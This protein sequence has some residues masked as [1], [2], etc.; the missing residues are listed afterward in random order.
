MFHYRKCGEKALTAVYKKD[1]SVLYQCDTCLEA[2]GKV[3]VVRE[4][5]SVTYRM[6][7]HRPNAA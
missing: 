4:F 6:V 2:E 7:G 3:L 1:G 5:G